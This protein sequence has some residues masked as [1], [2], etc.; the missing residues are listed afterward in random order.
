MARGWSAMV[1]EVVLGWTAEPRGIT[2]E[3]LLLSLAASLQHL[4]DSAP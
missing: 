4:V 3:N 2:R 1:E